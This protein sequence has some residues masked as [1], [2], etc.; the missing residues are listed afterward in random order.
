MI[1]RESSALIIPLDE[2]GRV[3]LTEAE[4]VALVEE[5]HRVFHEQWMESE[6]ALLTALNAL[7]PEEE[8][9]DG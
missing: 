6:V 4:R 9:D 7:V 8:D 3:V 1:R 2:R 5:F